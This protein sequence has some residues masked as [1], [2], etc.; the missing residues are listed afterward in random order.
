MVKK[1]FIIVNVLGSQSF[2]TYFSFSI[3]GFT[4]WECLRRKNL[5]HNFQAE[6]EFLMV[7]YQISNFSQR[8]ETF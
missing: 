5:L 8:L 4:D 7:I 2:L 1:L 3:I 6:Q